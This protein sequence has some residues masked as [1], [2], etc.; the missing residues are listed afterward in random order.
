MAHDGGIFAPCDPSR[1]QRDAK[2]N[3]DVFGFGRIQIVH[4][5]LARAFAANRQI[6][7]GDVK[8]THLERPALRTQ[9]AKGQVNDHGNASRIAPRPFHGLV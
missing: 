3:L 1:T 6:V 2:A 4:A 9:A 8:E 5:D 7:V